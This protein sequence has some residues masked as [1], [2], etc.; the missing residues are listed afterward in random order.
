MEIYF[1]RHGIAEER[2]DGLDHPD[3]ELTKPGRKKTEQVAQRIKQLGLKFDLVQTSP[4]QRALQTAQ[5]LI[6]AGLGSQ[7]EIC[8]YLS[9]EG[10]FQ[11]WLK[12]LE[13]QRF[14]EKSSDQEH[15]D[16]FQLALVGHEPDL[17]QWAETLIWGQPTQERIVLKKAGMIGVE[18]PTTGSPVGRSQM[19]WLT[20][21]RLL[22]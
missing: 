16:K 11:K 20:P 17:S 19:F 4:Y 13:N 6:D 10:D 21:P 2:Q 12:W 8:D 15:L 1:V 9:P 18:V 22:L 5:I 3:R 14:G 7:L